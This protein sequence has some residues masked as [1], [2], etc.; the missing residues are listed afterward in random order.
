[1]RKGRFVGEMQRG[2]STEDAILLAAN[3]GGGA[4]E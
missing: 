4:P 1:M 3:E 2:Q